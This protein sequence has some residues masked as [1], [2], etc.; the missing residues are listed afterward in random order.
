M[1]FIDIHTHNGAT[2]TSATIFNSP[3]YIEG[4]RI[5]LGIHPWEIEER[6]QERFRA[7]EEVAGNSN[8]VAIGECGI[9]HLKSAVSI[10]VQKEVLHAHALLA[11]RVKKPL[12]LHCVKGIDEIVAMHRSFADGQPWIIHGFRGKPQQAMQLT[13]VG[14]Y[15]SLGENFNKE[16]ARD[17]PA[18]RLFIESDE[19]RLPIEEIYRRVAEARN[20]STGELAMQI[21]ANASIFRAI[22]MHK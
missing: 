14:F 17:I 22:L 3:N 19:S 7:I 13:K 5:S 4:R 16:T 20:I 18:D 9:D 21:T 6:W 12:I 11:A 8:V 1:T 2:G 15:I 10:E